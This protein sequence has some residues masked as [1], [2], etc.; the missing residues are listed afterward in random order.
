M[1]QGL[2]EGTGY[3]NCYLDCWKFTCQVDFDLY[4]LR[5]VSRGSQYLFRELKYV[6]KNNIF[7]PD[8]APYQNRY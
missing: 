7:D 3:V 8:S 1:E 5:F 4:Q 2:S 6:L